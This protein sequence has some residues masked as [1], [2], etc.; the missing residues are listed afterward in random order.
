MQAAQGAAEVPLF[1]GKIADRRVDLLNAR[2]QNGIEVESGAD[3]DPQQEQ[4]Q[5]PEV[6]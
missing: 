6:A 5:C 1:V 4:S 2:V 3:D